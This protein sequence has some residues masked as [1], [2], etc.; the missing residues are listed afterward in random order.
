MNKFS[1]FK[2]PRISESLL[3]WQYFLTTLRKASRCCLFPRIITVSPTTYSWMRIE[4]IELCDLINNFLQR[5]CFS[6]VAL[7]PNLC[8][9]LK[10]LGHPPHYRWPQVIH[11]STTSSFYFNSKG[12]SASVLGTIPWL[13]CCFFVPFVFF[14]FWGRNYKY[15]RG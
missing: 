9:F 15:T 13:H 5:F 6:P 10:D 2:L 14:Y 3:Q 1:I 11:L 4:K 7:K 8:I 12:N